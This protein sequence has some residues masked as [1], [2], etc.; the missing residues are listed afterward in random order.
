M[1]GAADV[2]P[3]DLPS[4]APPDLH[5]SLGAPG[6]AYCP[7]WAWQV[8]RARA[9]AAGE[10]PEAVA[11]VE[12][13]PTYTLGRA[14]DASHLLLDAAAYAARGAEVVPVDRGGD[15][16]WHGPG[17]LTGY[18]ILHLGRRGRDIHGYVRSLEAC[19]V[20]V[21]ATYGIAAHRAEGRPGIWVGDAKLA[22]IGVKV[23]RWV[24]FHGFAL[25][26]AP[27]LGWFD[28]MV[29]C[30]LHG[31]GVTSVAALTGH[32]PP[33]GEVAG[34]LATALAARF[35]LGLG[36]PTPLPLESVGTAA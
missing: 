28:L 16:T 18:P 21:A 8:A 23:A 34:R 5:V 31:F 13:A 7:A 22:A 15:V 25:N 12:H 3:L 32:A 20:E 27:D 35:D 19:L 36:T 33:M 11:L 30:G 24:T 29:P 4:R 10:A 26:V 14:A 6:V 1:T 17:Q 2:A 9:V